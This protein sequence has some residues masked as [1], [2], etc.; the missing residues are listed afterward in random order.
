M[1][2]IQRKIDVTF[3]LA[4][5]NFP[6]GGNTVKA[7]GL[8][9]SA[10][11][12]NAGGV[13]MPIAQVRIYGLTFD[14]MNQLSTM[15][16]KVFAVP[17]DVMTIE[18]GDDVDGMAVVFIGNVQN[19]YADFTSAPDVA[20][21]VDA[22]GL[23]QAATAS[24]PS[25]SFQGSADVATIMSGFASRMNLP[26]ENNNVNVKLSNP[27]FTGSIRDQALKCVQ[28][29]GISWNGAEGGV[30]A[31]WPKFG[32]R[33]G[34]IPLISPSTGLIGYPA[35]TADGVIFRTV[36]NRSIRFGG[37]IQ[38]QSSI[39]LDPRQRAPK[40]TPI[41]KNW[42]IYLMS[43]DLESQVFHGK[44]QTELGCFAVGTPPVVA[45]LPVVA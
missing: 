24:I 32:S 16:L 22:F 18:A 26:F 21:F 17:P 19:A 20:F 5:G 12:L 7:T 11:I 39:N 40:S 45:S 38:V 29:A 35:F 28:D 13:S 25:T 37:Q 27:V 3:R 6:G 8:R 10:K 4:S 31:I 36:F 9:V 42:I 23:L 34:Q 33:G 15:G 43:H 14:L 41:T 44:W 30:L 1:T 2:F